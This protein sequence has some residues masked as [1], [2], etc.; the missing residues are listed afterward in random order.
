M[1]VRT[2]TAW[3]V[4]TASDAAREVVEH[5]LAGAKAVH[6]GPPRCQDDNSGLSLSDTIGRAMANSVASIAPPDDS[7]RDEEVTAAADEYRI[8]VNPRGRSSP[9]ALPV[10]QRAAEVRATLFTGTV[11]GAGSS[12]P[13][14]PSLTPALCAEPRVRGG[15]PVG[16]WL[17]EPNGFFRDGL[18]DRDESMRVALVT[19][20]EEHGEVQSVHFVK[21]GGS[22]PNNQRMHPCRTNA[23]RQG[24]GARPPRRLR[25]LRVRERA[26]VDSTQHA[27]QGHLAVRGAELASASASALRQG[28][29]PVESSP[30]VW[31][32]LGGGW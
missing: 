24:R 23:H 17:H 22:H 6:L 20:N 25:P 30:G 12:V 21:V 27:P 2:L 5:P 1:R 13:G 19:V 15:K 9:C 11:L 7:L 29:V 16:E 3:A 8:T 14:T 18:H 26:C 4:V 10:Q 28:V 31:P 32:S